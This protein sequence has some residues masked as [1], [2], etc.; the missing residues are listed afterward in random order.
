LRETAR[1]RVR[2]LEAKGFEDVNLYDPVDSTVGGIH[3][4]F[5]VRGDPRTY[6]L[7]PKPEVPTTYLKKGWM[8]AGIAAAAMVAGAFLAFTG[9][10]DR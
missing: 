8:S 9:S 6:N 5:I 10:S 3:A 2:D 1:E 4:L 7:P